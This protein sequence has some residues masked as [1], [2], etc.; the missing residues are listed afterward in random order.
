MLLTVTVTLVVI[1][2][3]VAAALCFV[4]IARCVAAAQAHEQH[5]IWLLEIPGAT[6]YRMRT[7]DG[8][9]LARVGLRCVTCGSDRLDKICHAVSSSWVKWTGFGMR[10]GPKLGYWSHVCSGCGTELF[11]TKEPQP[12]PGP[13]S[14]A[15][16]RYGLNFRMWPNR[17]LRP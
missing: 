3:L 15:L 6:S 17:G 8:Q 10:T 7:R 4:S 2:V 14:S 16:A 1:V 13:A 9:D 5:E 11:R 12:G